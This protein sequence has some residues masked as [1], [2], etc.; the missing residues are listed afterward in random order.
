MA[1]VL[2]QGETPLDSTFNLARDC[3]STFRYMCCR[4]EKVRVRPINSGTPAPADGG[5]TGPAE[6]SVLELSLHVGT[7]NAEAVENLRDHHEFKLK[8]VTSSILMLGI[9]EA[10]SIF[11]TTAY[12]KINRVNFGPAGG[13]IVPDSLLFFNLAIMIFGEVILTDGLVAYLSSIWTNRYIIDVS[14]EW[15]KRDVFAMRCFCIWVA[16]SSYFCIAGVKT[17]LC[18]TSYVGEENLLD[19]ILTQCP[20]L[21]ELSDML[22]VGAEYFNTTQ[23]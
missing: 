4:K 6:P 15:E 13:P 5:A 20:L 10:S 1:D 3:R 9:V 19:P 16:F 7:N 21:P 8:V 11:I 14:A 17:P 23:P 12:S 18:F 2:L 22:S